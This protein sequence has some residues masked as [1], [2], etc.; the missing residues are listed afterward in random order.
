LKQKRLL[1][2]TFVLYNFIL[3]YSAQP[4]KLEPELLERS[5]L[6]GKV[7]NANSFSGS[8]DSAR[9]EDDDIVRFR[10]NIAENI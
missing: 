8:R 3:T 4:L 7:G 9:I 2:A 1:V 10:D 5:I 6:Q